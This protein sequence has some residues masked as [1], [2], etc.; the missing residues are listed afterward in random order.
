ML[1]GCV[2]LSVS[3]EPLL[4]VCCEGVRDV[5]GVLGTRLASQHLIVEWHALLQA[6]MTSLAE[7]YL[8]LQL[9][10]RQQQQQPPLRQPPLR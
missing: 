5:F 8:P 6:E 2:R 1:E 7:V 4:C 3:S 9:Q 10:H